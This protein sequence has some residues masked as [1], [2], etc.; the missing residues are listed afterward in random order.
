MS[1]V[2][3]I[4]VGGTKVAAQM[5]GQDG[6]G[7]HRQQPT[8]L[9]STDAL[10]DQFVHLVDKAA[11][12]ASID[13]VGI[14]VPSVVRFE[15]GEVVSSVNIPL[16]GVELRNLLGERLGVP[17]YVDNDGAVAALAEAHDEELK[18]AVANLVMLTIGTGVGG[19]VVIGGHI[20]R[21]ATGG[22]AELG[23]QLIALPADSDI[24]MAA[25]KFPQAG[26]LES[27]GSGSALDRFAREAA[28]A[29][30]DSGLG[31][32]A[33]GDDE[34]SG[35]DAVQAANDGCEVAIG[36]VR[37]W[38]HAIGIGVANA[39]N[40]FDPDEVVIGGGGAAAG[41]ILLDHA[42]EI[43]HGYVLTGLQGHAKIRFARFGAGAGVVGAALLAR[44]ELEA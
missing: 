14:G 10:I 26:S 27:L 6:L 30:P 35:K 31:R 23:H 21:G 37:R 32:I 36:V 33:A 38:A 4:D 25:D 20:F 5:L 3:G 43:A 22:A 19:G 24:P 11:G 1:N 28:A 12:G 9:D 39:I 16:A 15:T 7:E 41:Q 2:V 44:H 42:S 34:V 8:E 40:T 18:L 13:A 29:H 17:V